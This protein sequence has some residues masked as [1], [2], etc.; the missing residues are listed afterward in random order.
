M[1][2]L[3]T[4]RFDLDDGQQAAVHVRKETTER[5]L[6][7]GRDLV[8]LHGWITTADAEMHRTLADTLR[9]LDDR[10]VSAWD[11]AGEFSGR[12][13]VSWNSYGES[14]GVHTY[15]VLLREAEELTLDV[16]LVDGLQLHPYEYREQVAGEG[17]ILHAKVEGTDETL[18]RLR[19]LVRSGATLP[20]VRRGI[21]EEP[22]EMRFGV[23]QWSRMEDRTKCRLVLVDRDLG[24]SG[25][26]EL[27]RV[28]EEN[29]R[30]ALGFH[31]NFLERLAELLVDRGILSRAELQALREEVRD[32]PGIARRDLWRVADVDGP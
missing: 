6:H 2:E 8:E 13:C 16:L 17:L 15:T 21:N 3:R 18:Q 29:S 14:A 12:W 7:T 27:V 25:H 19:E 22:R 31:G 28:E 1:T 20:V 10:P 11:E 32:A 23:A 26:A 30:A 4:L 5:S 24:E 9:S